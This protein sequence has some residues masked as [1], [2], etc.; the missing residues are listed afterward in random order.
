MVDK[1]D[2]SRNCAI[3]LDQQ[4][5]LSACRDKFILPK[6]VSGSPYI[7][8]CGNSL[9]LQPKQTKDHISEVLDQWATKGVKGHFNGEK[10]WLDYN[11]R[12]NPMMADIVGARP[13]EVVIANTL[14]VN[15]H[16]MLVSFYRPKGK[17]IKILMESDAFP[18]DRYAIASYLRHV[19]LDPDEVIQTVAPR[20]GEVLLHTSDIVGRIEE[21]GNELALVLMGNTNYYT[22]QKLEIGK[23]TEAGHRVGALVGFDCAHGAG[24]IPLDLHDNGVDFAIWCTYKYLNASPGNL[25]GI[26]IHQRHAN[27]LKVPRLQGWWGEDKIRRFQMRDEFKPQ[28]GAEGW[29]I[30]NPPIVALAAIESSLKIHYDIGM[31]AIR[32]KSITLTAYLAYLINELQHDQ[33]SIITPSDPELRGAQLSLLIKDGSKDIYDRLLS[34]GVITDWREPDVIRVSPAPL[35]NSYEDVYKFVKIMDVSLSSCTA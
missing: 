14:T 7:Y 27:D 35:Y 23:I 10:P 17:R 26:Y 33:V 12:L 24:N 28:Q 2:T 18:S 29:Q 4:D 16:L 32:A 1:Y 34:S 30:S 3:G 9:G 13:D 20:S 25:G 19:N 22:G 8:L 5:P 31:T 15:L 6:T 21:L 11:E